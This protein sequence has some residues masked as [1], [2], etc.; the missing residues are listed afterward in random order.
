MA[1]SRNGAGS[2]K[3]LQCR[4][5]GFVAECLASHCRSL[6][7]EPV[8]HQASPCTPYLGSV[9][10]K[11]A[12]ATNCKKTAW[13]EIS[14]YKEIQYLVSASRSV[15]TVWVVRNV[16]RED[17]C[18]THVLHQQDLVVWASARP[19][20]HVQPSPTKASSFT[21]SGTFSPSRAVTPSSNSLRFAVWISLPLAWR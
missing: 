21:L 12:I 18:C 20:P 1:A 19:P 7:Q 11:L 13:H 15:R 9:D 3:G 5:V 16:L 2:G 17:L 6:G 10:Y 8:K 14:N 4:T